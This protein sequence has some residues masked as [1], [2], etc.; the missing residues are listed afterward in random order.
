MAQIVKKVY[1]P[2]GTGKTTRLMALV[3]QEVASGTPLSRIGYISFTR[4]AREVIMERMDASEADLRWFRTIHGACLK[5]KGMGGA[6]MGWQ[7]YKVFSQKYGMTVRPDDEYEEFVANDYTVALRAY[8]LSCATKRPLEDIVRDM[9]AHPA[10]TPGKLGYF[11]EKWHEFKKDNG[12]FDFNDMLTI[13]DKSPVPMPVDA[14]FVDEAQDLSRLQWDI[15][16]SMS[17][18]VKR[19]YMAGDD[20][21]SIFGFIGA[22]EYGFLERPCDEEELLQQSYRVPAG[23]GAA[24]DAVIKRVNLRKDK[25]VKWK[26]APGSVT[27][28]GLQAMQMPWHKWLETH[29]GIMVLCR[30]RR[31]ASSVSTELQSIGMPHTLHGVG[32]VDTKLARMVRSYMAL[33]RGESITPVQAQKLMGLAGQTIPKPTGKVFKKDLPLDFVSN[34]WTEQFGRSKNLLAIAKLLDQGVDLDKPPAIDV[35][36]MH[37]AKGRE[38]DLIVIVPDCSGIVRH[39]LNTAT[40]IRLSYVALTRAKREVAI[41]LP[42]T[43]S[44]ITHFF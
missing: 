11:L 41:V 20:D 23:I 26:D 18:G 1:G 7:D 33:R 6:V 19:I 14:L 2:P 8:N 29:K 40:E 39:N 42:Q 37:G 21:Q 32:A 9:P 43:D 36:T 10:L 17:R 5:L 3:E 27:K 15:V 12:K 28:M 44:Y 35:G 24:A 30:H 4:S 22:D 38:Q 25:G 34:N 31:G 16:T 13:Y